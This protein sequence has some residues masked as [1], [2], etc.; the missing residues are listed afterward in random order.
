V[1]VSLNVVRSAEEIREALGLIPTLSS[2]SAAL[3]SLLGGGYRPGELV[4]I[5]GKSNVGKTQVAM[6]AVLQASTKG[7]TSVFIDSEGTFRPERVESMAKA[8]GLERKGLLDK[9]VYVRVD[10]A[11]AQ[12]DAIR[13]LREKGETSS[14]RLVVVDTLTRNFTLDYPGGANLVRRQGALDV[15]LSEMA[16]DAVAHGRSYLLTNRVT[17]DQSGGETRIGGSTLEQMVHTSIHMTKERGLLRLA[18][19]EGQGGAQ[20][21]SLGD[22]GLE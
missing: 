12:A 22:R 20:E 11:A 1:G 19:A 9:I 15:H 14:S 17:F 6:Q 3:D 4:E 18:R 7:H 13:A 16:R 8:R 10:T 5:Y 2:G 21:S